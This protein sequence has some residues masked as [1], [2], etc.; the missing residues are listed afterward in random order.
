[1][2]A[3]LLLVSA[4]V[5][6]LLIGLAGYRWMLGDSNETSLLVVT[7]LVV[8]FASL[9]LALVRA[10]PGVQVATLLVVGVLLVPT[11]GLLWIMGQTAGSEASVSIVGLDVKELWWRVG[12]VGIVAM[13]GGLLLALRS[14]RPEAGKRPVS[15]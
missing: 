1:V 3:A 2:R 13:A 14:A 4:S 12:M 8:G 5:G 6:L 7:L 15:D 9:A 11:A 10:S